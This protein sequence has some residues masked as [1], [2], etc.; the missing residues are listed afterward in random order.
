M[1]STAPSALKIRLPSGS[2]RTC[3]VTSAVASIAQHAAA[4]VGAEHQAERH[5]RRHHAGGGAGCAISSTIARL[6]IGQHRQH[7]ADD[8]VE[9]RPRSA[10]RRAARAPPAIRSAAGSRRR[11]AAAPAVISPRPIS[12][13][14][15]RADAA[16]LARDEHHHADEDQQRRQP[17][18]VEREHH[19]HQAGADVGAE[20]HRQ[21]GA[22]GDQALADEA[23]RRSGRWRCSTAPGWSRRG[24]PAA[25]ADAVA[26]AARQH[27]AQV[28]AEHPQHAG[29]HDV[30]APD[31]QGDRGEEV[32]EVDQIRCG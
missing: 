14:P 16:V 21:R 9:Q 11:S 18:Q 28:L 15:M 32:E 1:T 17:R 24:R 30:R 13:R 12:T 26:E 4:D 3:G 27:A 10:A 22:G 29:A 25:R 31:Q 8:D 23:R 5:R 2:R 7:R 6:G 19:R 20:H